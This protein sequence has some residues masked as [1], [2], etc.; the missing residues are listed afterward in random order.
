MHSAGEEP[1]FRSSGTVS[2]P[3]NVGFDSVLKMENWGMFSI[4]PPPMVHDTMSKKGKRKPTL[5]E[6]YGKQTTDLRYS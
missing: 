4:I 1:K 2:A 3:R 5:Q 6:G